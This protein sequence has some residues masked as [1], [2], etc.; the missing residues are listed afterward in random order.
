M[1]SVEEAKELVVRNSFSLP[2]VERAITSALFHVLA[3]DVVS[4]VNYPPFSQ[5]AMDGYAIKFSDYAA[6][7]KIKVIGE[8]PAGKPFRKKIISGQAVRIFTGSEIPDGADT[9][10]MQENVSVHQQILSIVG[11]D[12]HTGLNIRRKASQVKKGQIILKKGTLLNAGAIGFLAGLGIMRVKVFPKPKVSVIV[13]GNELQKPGAKLRAGKIYE[14]NS[15]TL[16][17]ALASL[18]FRSAESVMVGDNKKNISRKIKNAITRSDIVLISGGVSV[19][20]YDYVNGCLRNLGVRT[21]F[22]K[23]SQKPGKPILFGKIKK[24]LVFGLPG[25]PAAALTCFYEYV[26]PAINKMQ[27]NPEIFLKKEIMPVLSSVKKKKGISFFLKGKVDNGK[28]EV[29]HGQDSGNI[30]AFALADC[31]VYIPQEKGDV[32]A[33]E[34]VEIHPI[35]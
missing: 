11:F 5:S 30:G 28:V 7:K 23:V 25:N 12:L 22:H 1:I 32:K 2:P 17:A 6:G 19:G 20:D 21:I 3:K 34:M 18:H 29:L 10:V 24:C 15:F 8:A 13:T 14:S 31:L 4:P 33:G 27:G 9:V 35:K 16:N 26:L